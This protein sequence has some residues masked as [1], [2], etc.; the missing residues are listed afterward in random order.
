MSIDSA[1]V[2]WKLMCRPMTVRIS[3]V[4]SPCVVWWPAAVHSVDQPSKHRRHTV[5]YY[6]SLHREQRGA[7]GAKDK[8]PQQNA[9]KVTAHPTQNVLFSTRSLSAFSLAVAAR[10]FCATRD[11][12]IYCIS[13]AR[14]SS[15]A[16]LCCELWEGCC[17]GEN[18]RQNWN[19]QCIQQFW[20]EIFVVTT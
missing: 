13:A 12:A 9:L 16:F 2:S 11:D 20:F 4:R 1:A 5:Y 17:A 8:I 19:F 3:G 15:T 6:T 14:T 18:T 7:R 10:V